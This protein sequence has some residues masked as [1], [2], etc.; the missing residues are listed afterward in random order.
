MIKSDYFKI[1]TAVIGWRNTAMK[2]GDQDGT[3]RNLAV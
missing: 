2:H 3:V 1:M